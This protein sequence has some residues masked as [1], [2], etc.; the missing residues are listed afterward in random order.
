MVLDLRGALL[1]SQQTIVYATV[2]G[3][4]LELI[5]PEGVAVLV[6][7]KSV[8]GRKVVRG[9]PQPL[10]GQPVVEVRA[11]TVGGTIK[12]TVPRRSRWRPRR[13]RTAS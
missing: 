4:H 10:P 12:A 7:G 1:Q 9:S 6:S 13:G 2:I 11:V 8:L 5:V 3:G